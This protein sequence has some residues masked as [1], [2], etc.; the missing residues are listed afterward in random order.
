MGRQLHAILR[1]FHKL[2][3]LTGGGPHK[4]Q[5]RVRVDQA[6]GVEGADQ[7]PNVPAETA[8]RYAVAKGHCMVP[9]AAANSLPE[10]P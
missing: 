8:N 2:R 6:P 3:F 7:A 4:A 9:H 1:I 5:D 10:W